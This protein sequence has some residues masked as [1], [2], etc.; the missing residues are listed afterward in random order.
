LARW[1]VLA[2][3]EAED[4]M[5]KERR[6]S[7]GPRRQVLAICLAYSRADS[8]KQA[9]CGKGAIESKPDGDHLP[10]TAARCTPHCESYERFDGH[11]LRTPVT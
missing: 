10:F 8:G 6:P 4:I 5:G 9:T 7:R 2:H 3:I 1:F 11:A